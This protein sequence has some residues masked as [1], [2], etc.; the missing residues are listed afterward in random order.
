MSV[1]LDVIT[2]MVWLWNFRSTIYDDLSHDSLN[3]HHAEYT[4]WKI[5][6]Y[7]Y[8]ADIWKSFLNSLRPSD[9]YMRQ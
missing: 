4:S 5:D 2:E 3:P 6:I 9:A 7:L 8:D 1:N